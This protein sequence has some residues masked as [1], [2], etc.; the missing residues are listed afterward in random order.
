MGPYAGKKSD[1]TQGARGGSV[2]MSLER[3]VPAHHTARRP[4]TSETQIEMVKLYTPFSFTNRSWLERFCLYG[5]DL[6]RV[7]R[8]EA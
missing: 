4:E 5:N 3:K 1:F 8:K 7:K 2:P 6:Q